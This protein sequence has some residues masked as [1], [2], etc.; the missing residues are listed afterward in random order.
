MREAPQEWQNCALWEQG[1]ED[2]QGASREHVGIPGQGADTDDRVQ[3]PYIP[4]LAAAWL[5]EQGVCA[6]E[7]NGEAARVAHQEAEVEP[8]Q[9]ETPKEP[10]RAA[11]ETPVPSTVSL[12]AAKRSKILL[13]S[14]DVIDQEENQAACGVIGKAFAPGVGRKEI[15]DAIVKRCGIKS[16]GLMTFSAGKFQVVMNSREEAQQLLDWELR[17]LGR[18]SQIIKWSPEACRNMSELDVAI[19]WVLLPKLPLQC[20]ESLKTISNALGLYISTEKTREEMFN[21]ATPIIGVQIADATPLQMEV[22]VA[23]TNAR[24]DLVE[25]T[26]RVEYRDWTYACNHCGSKGHCHRQCAKEKAPELGKAP[27]REEA[28]QAEL[29]WALRVS[30]G[31]GQE[32]STRTPTTTVGQ[33]T[34]E[35]RAGLSHAQAYQADRRAAE[36]LFPGLDIEG[37]VTFKV[38][39][40]L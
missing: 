1:L 4:P 7:G 34:Q 33:S 16:L 18:P 13:P 35:R 2:S 15:E 5:E 39:L 3:Q 25:H 26:Q 11:A 23:W 38:C 29:T 31:A 27:T 22:E 40:V 19:Y 28:K 9:H 32:G 20:V 10:K 6:A 24:G 12:P 17:I 21:G 37:K 30:R 8:A 36:V 14:L